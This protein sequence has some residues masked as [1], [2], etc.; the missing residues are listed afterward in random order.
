MWS[1]LNFSEERK[2]NYAL[3]HKF[4]VNVQVTICDVVKYV[5]GN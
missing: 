5:K 4:Y 3:I 2:L 1:F